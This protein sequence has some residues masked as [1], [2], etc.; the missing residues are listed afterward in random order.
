VLHL[1]LLLLLYGYPAA[2]AGPLPWN[3]LLPSLAALLWDCQLQL[4]LLLLLGQPPQQQLLVLLHRL[5]QHP[6]HHPL[7]LPYQATL[8]ASPLHLLLQQALL[9]LRPAVLH[10]TAQSSRSATSQLGYHTAHNPALHVHC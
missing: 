10:R 6:A 9:L 4:L 2:A 7:L 8:P 3:P 1:L 5:L